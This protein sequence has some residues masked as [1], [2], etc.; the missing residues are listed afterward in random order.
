MTTIVDVLG[1]QILDSR[2]NP[3]IEVEVELDVGR[4]RPRRRAV[5][6]L[7]G[8]VRGRRAARR[9]RATLRRQGRAQG[10]RERQRDHRR[11]DHRLRRHRPAA[12]RPGADRAR[13]HAQQGEARRQR[14]PG[15]LAGRRQRRGQRPRAAALPLPR[16]R[17]RARPAGADDEHPERRQARRQQRRPAGVHGHA[18]GR[19][20]FAEALRMGAEVYHALKGVLKKRGLSTAVGDEGGFAPNLGSN[21]EAIEVI[22]EAIDAGRLQ[23][24]RAGLHRPRSG[25]HRASSRTA[26]TSSPARAAA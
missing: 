18:G 11:G 16:R 9:R 26:S 7:D 3:T 22:I 12:H 25:R 10:G 14:H 5:G 23:G 15:R 6:R 4:R 17:G 1:R 20:L 19:R 21:A 8:R 13:R 24:R 2:G